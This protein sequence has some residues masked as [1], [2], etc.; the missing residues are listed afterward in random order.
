MAASFP[1]SYLS[2]SASF[3]GSSSRAGSISTIFPFSF[4]FCSATYR[5]MRAESLSRSP[6]SSRSV[7]VMV[8]SGAATASPVTVPGV[9]PDQA[10]GTPERG[11]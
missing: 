3:G 9:P 4:P 8:N 6:S 1:S 11:A 5:A 10:F 2:L 7:S